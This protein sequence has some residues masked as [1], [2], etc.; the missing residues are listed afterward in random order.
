MGFQ[1]DTALRFV[2]VVFQLHIALRYLQ[3]GFQLD[4]ALRYSILRYVIETRY[5]LGMLIPGLAEVDTSW[6]CE[7][8][9]T[10]SWWS[11]TNI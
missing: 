1:L 2:Q 5:Q 4:T 11:G 10:S 9:N 7:V 8:C 3:T 6:Y